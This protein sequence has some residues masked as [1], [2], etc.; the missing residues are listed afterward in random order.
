[1]NNNENNQKMKN[2]Q[3]TEAKARRKINKSWEHVETKRR[4]KRAATHQ[5]CMNT[6]SIIVAECF[7]G[8]LLQLNER[9]DSKSYN[10]QKRILRRIV[11]KRQAQSI[12]HTIGRSRDRF[13]NHMRNHSISKSVKE[14]RKI[15]FC[16]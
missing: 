14:L 1:M 16:A 2:K 15:Q 6:T 3:Q 11:E 12:H 7:D 13:A 8:I 4:Y 9:S 10:Y 5:A